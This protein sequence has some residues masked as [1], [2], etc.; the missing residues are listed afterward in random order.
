MLKILEFYSTWCQPCKQLKPIL[1]EIEKEFSYVAV[2]KINVEINDE[3]A[4]LYE[5]RS[6]PTLLIFKDNILVDKIIG[7]VPKNKIINTIEKHK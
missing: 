7:K 1:E 3:A 2:E 5:I 6:V 4:N